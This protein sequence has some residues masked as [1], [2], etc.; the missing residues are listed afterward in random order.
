VEEVLRQ[1]S[2]RWKATDFLIRASA[3]QLN[4]ALQHLESSGREQCE[5]A[6]DLRWL[7]RTHALNAEDIRS[8]LNSELSI[9]RKFG[10]AA[11]ARSKQPNDSLLE[12]AANADDSEIR[13]MA[14]DV[15]SR[16]KL[17]R[18]I[19]QRRDARRRQQS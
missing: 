2:V 17:E 19:A 13:D 6:T 1:R 9:Q 16:R 3:D 18:D 7:I 14:D 4:E 12:E 15:L 5:I 8:Q 10:I 11:A